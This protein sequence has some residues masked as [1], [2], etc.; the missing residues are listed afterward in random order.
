MSQQA[1]VRRIVEA[2]KTH[3]DVITWNKDW[4]LVYNNEPVSKTYVVDLVNNLVRTKKNFNPVGSAVFLKGLKEI[5]FPHSY[6]GNDIRHQQKLTS[7]GTTLATPKS[8]NP[9]PNL[10]TLWKIK[11]QNVYMCILF[12]KQIEKISV[13]LLIIG[14]NYITDSQ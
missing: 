13:Y 3:S 5:N 2:M 6:I 12:I 1:K 7:P 9:F 11:Q 10:E 8:S 14:E 4:E